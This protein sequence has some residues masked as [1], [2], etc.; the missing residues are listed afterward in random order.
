MGGLLDFNLAVCRALNFSCV[1]RCL[2][3]G[4]FTFIVLFV[5]F[6]DVGYFMISFLCWWVMGVF[7]S[8][9]LTIRCLFTYY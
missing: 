4:L 6:I 8:T 1:V 3:L 5:T 7:N 2:S 9:Y